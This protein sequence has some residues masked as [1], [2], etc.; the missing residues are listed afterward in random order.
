MLFLSDP[1]TKQRQQFSQTQQRQKEERSA[2]VILINNNNH[3]CS[4]EA[5]LHANRL[6]RD[7]LGNRSSVSEVEPT[8]TDCQIAHKHEA[9]PQ[10]LWTRG[11][12]FHGSNQSSQSGS[13]VY[14]KGRRSRYISAPEQAL[15]L[16]THVARPY[17][18]SPRWTLRTCYMHTTAC[19]ALN[20]A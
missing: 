3:L 15:Y 12:S 10:G 16:T 6:S 7:E 4:C 20:G 13:C 19:F 14:M 2:A 1:H 17:F 9:P 18:E 5:S 8:A 11:P